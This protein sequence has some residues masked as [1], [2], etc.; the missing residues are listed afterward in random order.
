MLGRLVLCI[1]FMVT[2]LQ[3]QDLDSLRQ[4][5]NQQSDDNRIARTWLNAGVSLQSDGNHS[6]AA[7]AFKE[8]MR[9]AE[10]LGN[11]DL[12]LELHLHLAKSYYELSNTQNALIH[13]RLYSILSEQRGEEN[14]E[15][16]KA[17]LENL[18]QLEVTALEEQINEASTQLESSQSKVIGLR[19]YQTLF[20]LLLALSVGGGFLYYRKYKAESQEED[21]APEPEVGQDT[22]ADRNKELELK[23]NSSIDL[24]NKA[25]AGLL[26]LEKDFKK[27]LPDSF[28]LHR[29]RQKAGADFLWFGEADGRIVLAIADC[30]A[31]DVSGVLIS[32]VINKFLNQIVIEGQITA[33]NMA[34]SLVDQNIR[35]KINPDAD[36]HFYGV[37]IAIC[38]I[39]PNKGEVE[40][41]GSKMPVYYAANGDLQRLEGNRFPA[42]SPHIQEKFYHTETTSLTKDGMLYLA[43]DGFSNQF[44]GKQNKKFMRPAFEK[45]LNS[46]WNQKVSEQYFVLQKVLD[47][48][49]GRKDQTDDILVV[50]IKL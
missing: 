10:I 20:F 46:V 38:A 48:W 35:Q 19:I 16:E 7:E 6:E 13:F 5:V 50:G 12:I 33:P 18:H 24:A 23:L 36:S 21:T 28:V 17:R 39:D 34:L 40:Y 15:S 30:S 44:G 11:E 14:F 25:Q 37:K 47:D 4:A 27:L 29:P 22:A 41:S 32:M 2:S 1:S 49:K 43:T 8:S 3:A 31:N 9:V 45:L 26:P 42:G